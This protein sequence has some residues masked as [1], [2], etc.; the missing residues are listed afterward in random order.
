MYA[1]IHHSHT[2]LIPGWFGYRLR[3]TIRCLITPRYPIMTRHDIGRATSSAVGWR[4]GVGAGLRRMA[5]ARLRRQKTRAGTYKN[6]FLFILLNKYKY[7]SR[8][9]IY[10]LACE[11][12]CARGRR[13]T[14]ACPS[15]CRWGPIAYKALHNKDTLHI[16]HYIIRTLCI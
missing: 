5:G 4:V 2:R 10:V 16:K 3:A 13:S 14:G 11:P 12:R 9:R 15:R 7:V 8:V 1:R 6:E